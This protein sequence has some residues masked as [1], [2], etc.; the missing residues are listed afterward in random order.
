MHHVV[1]LNFTIK[2]HDD[3]LLKTMTNIISN[4]TNLKTK[5]NLPFM[6]FEGVFKI[7][8]VIFRTEKSLF[9]IFF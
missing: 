5:L 8:H 9:I 4:T 3:F 1:T 2:T 7:Y 6:T